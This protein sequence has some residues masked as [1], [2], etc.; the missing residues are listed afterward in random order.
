[1]RAVLEHVGDG[2]QSLTVSLDMCDE[3]VLLDLLQQAN[4]WS[5]HGKAHT[6]HVLHS[7]QIVYIK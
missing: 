1:M 6:D 5:E 2:G 3:E 4:A 7:G